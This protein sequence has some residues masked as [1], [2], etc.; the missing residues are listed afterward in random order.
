M[1]VSLSVVAHLQ[2]RLPQRPTYTNCGNPGERVVRQC[3]R[4]RTL[5]FEGKLTDCMMCT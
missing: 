1:A 2:P 5:A 3:L 4:E